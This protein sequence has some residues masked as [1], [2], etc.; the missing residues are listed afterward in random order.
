M[1][2]LPLLLISAALVTLPGVVVASD[3]EPLFGP[4]TPARISGEWVHQ[5]LLTEGDVDMV[6]EL[7]AS[8]DGAR[9]RFTV[10][11]DDPRFGGVTEVI[12]SWD[13]W[14]P[15]ALVVISES[16]WV[17]G[18]GGD[19]WTGSSR[20]A[21]SMAD[22]DPINVPEQLFLDGAGAYEGL[23]AYVIID[24]ATET[25]IGVILPDEMPELPPD[26]MEIWQEATSDDPADAEPQG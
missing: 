6:G 17:V 4:M 18:D 22:D 26:W 1:R 13:G 7:M 15:P 8:M 14:W 16:Q 25:F 5:E 21:A 2:E 9:S 24:H 20:Q 3:E 19:T 11:S 12:G 10:T 23:T